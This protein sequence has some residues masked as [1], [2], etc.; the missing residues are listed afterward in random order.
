[1]ALDRGFIHSFV[2]MVLYT[3]QCISRI[4]CNE[5][6]AT[7]LYSWRILQNTMK[8]CAV[9]DEELGLAAFGPMAQIK[10]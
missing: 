8:E 7:Y 6:I 10:N 1:M 2:K 4:S 3:V 5:S 9:A